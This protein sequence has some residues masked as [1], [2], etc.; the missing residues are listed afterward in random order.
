MLIAQTVLNGR[1]NISEEDDGPLSRLFSVDIWK[2]GWEITL[3]LLMPV[4]I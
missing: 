2:K 4:R 3:R 1:V